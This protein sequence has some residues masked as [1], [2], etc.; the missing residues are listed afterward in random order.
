MTEFTRAVYK[1]ERTEVVIKQ[2][3]YD[4]M[5]EIYLE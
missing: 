5:K 1:V 2:D 4:Q 3:V